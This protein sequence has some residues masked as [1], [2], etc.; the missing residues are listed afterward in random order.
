MVYSSFSTS[1]LLTF[2]LDNSLSSGAPVYCRIVYSIPGLSPLDGVTVAP[3]SPPLVMTNKNVSR[4]W[5]MF[6]VGGGKG[7]ITTGWEPVDY[8]NLRYR[9]N[10]KP[11]S[12]LQES[13][14]TPDPTWYSQIF[15]YNDFQ[16]PFWLI[17]S[18]SQYITESPRW[19][20]EQKCKGHYL[21]EEYYCISP[22]S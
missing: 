16:D 19:Q 13:S 5:Q 10:H 2:G 3:F 22:L 9:I 17:I 21:E 7:K 4:H 6:W 18:S 1:A 12:T 8:R 11:S 20:W 14:G 15:Y